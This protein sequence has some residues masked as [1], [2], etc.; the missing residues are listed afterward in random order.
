MY[1]ALYNALIM[2]L[3]DVVKDEPE[4]VKVF[5]S[6]LVRGADG[7]GCGHGVLDAFGEV[8]REASEYYGEYLGGVILAATLRYCNA[9]VM[10]E[11]MHVTDVSSF[12]ST[13]LYVSMTELMC[14]ILT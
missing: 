9:V 6:R 3:D 13:P 7:G 2:Y 14:E 1:I 4:L 12:S 11:E 8:V 5:G 10:E